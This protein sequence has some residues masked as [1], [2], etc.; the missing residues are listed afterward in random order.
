MNTKK[1][2]AKQPVWSER[3]R[4]SPSKIN[5][6]Y[7]AGRDIEPKPPA[8]ELLIP[9]DIWTNRAHTLML[10]RQKIISKKIARSILHSLEKISVL[11]RKNQF[12][13]D[14][15]L[16][17]VHM[18][19]EH[20]IAEDAGEESAGWL[21]TGR[22]R[23]DQS[24]TDIRLYVRDRLLEKIEGTIELI[25][26]LLRQ[27]EN[28]I[29]T[30]MPGLTH[31]R[32]ATL[33]TW[34]HYLVSYAQALERDTTRLQ[35]AYETVDQSP[36]GSAASFGTSWHIDRNY[37]AQ[38]LGFQRVQLNTIDCLTNR[39]ETEAEA[40][41]AIC[42][43]LIHLSI[44]AE[45]L[46]IFTLPPF[47]LIE[48]DSRYVTG[49]SIMPQ[50]RNLDFAEVTRA[51]ASLIQG[52][53]QAL[54]GIGRASTSGYNRD[55][56][57][58]K[59]IIIDV[60]DEARYSAKLFRDIFSTLKVNREQMARIADLGFL[61]ATEVADFL[62][63]NYNIPYRM[64]YKIVAEAVSAS[65]PEQ[66]LALDKLNRVLKQNNTN[67]QI[68]A[69]EWKQLRNFKEIIKSKTHLGGSAPEAI[70][71]NIAYLMSLITQHRKW[72]T[73][74]TKSLDKAK[75]LLNQEIKALL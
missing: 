1:P 10:Y 62:T 46:L 4:V 19:I 28:H 6:L 44:I 14:Q 17:D 8:D 2:G 42:F 55:E 23:N 34:A 21:H 27:A 72:L 53:V 45:D 7:T 52:Y 51:K 61:N 65:E 49:S 40:A 22:S 50:K 74:K 60:F 18:N 68:S 64:A 25:E 58:T 66:Q 31:L 73:Q 41:I 32:F 75:R 35:N 5:I 15:Q 9:Y 39:W 37:T 20:F 36:L 29:E 70:K 11:Y 56:Q 67:I 13:L 69:K 38:L 63:R 48:I 54:M 47:E 57:W 24:T 43:L 26:V 71:E 59:F 12:H 30:I 3:T 16:E 33:T